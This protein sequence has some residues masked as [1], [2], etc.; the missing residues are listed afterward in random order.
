MASR[1]DAGAPIDGVAAALSSLCLFHCLL[2]PL[3]LGLAPVVAHVLAKAARARRG[4]D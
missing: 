4:E 3:G 1:P 2:L